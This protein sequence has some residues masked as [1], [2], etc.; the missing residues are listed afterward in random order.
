MGIVKVAKTLGIGVL[1]CPAGVRSG[2]VMGA[3]QDR[4]K[5]AMTDNHARY[6]TSFLRSWL[7]EHTWGTVGLCFQLGF[8]LAGALVVLPR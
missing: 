3:R 5:F 8:L 2:G 1:G 6:T 4:D 7:P